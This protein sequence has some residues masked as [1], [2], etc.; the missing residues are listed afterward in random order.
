MRTL[1]PVVL[2]ACP[3]ASSLQLSRTCI[4]TSRNSVQRVFVLADIQRGQPG[5]KRQQTRRLLNRLLGKKSAGV[6]PDS[7]VEEPLETIA[8]SLAADAA[9]A[10]EPPEV[11]GVEAVTKEAASEKAVEEV[12]TAV[13]AAADQ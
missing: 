4:I 11:D 2:L 6:Q 1:L 9:T 7:P 5:Y 3:C 8:V 10:E 13:A 12:V